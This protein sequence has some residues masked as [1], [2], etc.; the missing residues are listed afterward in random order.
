LE[1]SRSHIAVGGSLYLVNGN[2]VITNCGVLC[3]PALADDL[4]LTSI[5]FTR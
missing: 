4:N 3:G 2:G 5:L 1:T